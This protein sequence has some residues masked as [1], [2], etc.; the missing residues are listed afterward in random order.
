MKDKKKILSIVFMVV[1]AIILICSMIFIY[2]TVKDKEQPDGPG[3]STPVSKT[4]DFNNKIIK[5]VHSN[6]EN[7][8]YMI[9]PYSLEVV[10]SMLRDGASEGT[11]EELN[12]LVPERDIKTFEVKERI[13][14][15]NALFI[16]NGI[17]VKDNFKNIMTNKYQSEVIVDEFTTPKAIND[18]ANKETYGM[19][20]KVLETVGDNFLLG[21]G[22]AVAIDVEWKKKFECS[23]TK[24]EEF[25][26]LD[27]NKIDVAMM[28][29]Y[30]E[31]G[32][33]Y[34]K[35]SNATYVSIPYRSYSS[36]GEYDR[37]GIQL[38]FV[39]ILP[40]EDV[41]SYISSFNFND[42][43]SV[44]KKMEEA[45]D[46]FNIRLS[47]PK[48]KYDYSVEGLKGILDDLGLKETFGLK[49]NFEKIAD[50]D[51]SISEVVHKSFI[52][53]GESG[54]KAAAVT[55]ITIADNAIATEKPKVVE[56]NFNKPFVYL[57][58]DKSS[59]E[60]LFFGV[61]YSPTEYTENDV[62]CEEVDE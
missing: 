3:A 56:V 36:D 30:Y 17:K 60:I 4:S 37:N 33:S 49:P 29:N 40:E 20:P 44:V 39:G 31:G 51:M 21:L 41:D 52:D 53:L 1:V 12:K 23:S 9:S 25:T 7:E 24:L 11:L 22:N 55:V 18:W 26:K 45:S 8:N 58:K 14:V 2:K 16:K 19:I 43:G 59:D 13:N 62:L 32:A 42:I 5:A 28:H 15:A 35:D 34:Y 57:I 50:Y 61:V 47:L 27:G 6:V 48:F 38:E 54:T 10:L 46:E